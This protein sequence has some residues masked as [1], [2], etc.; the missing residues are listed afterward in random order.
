M[1]SNTTRTSESPILPAVIPLT[2]TLF[3]PQPLVH[4]STTSHTT[5]DA[6]N[7]ASPPPS[8]VPISTTVISITTGTTKPTSDEPSTSVSYS[9]SSPLASSIS[10]LPSSSILSAPAPSS[11]PSSTTRPA[12]TST[13][14][15]LSASN[16]STRITY[17]AILP[18]TFGAFILISCIL[19]VRRYC[20]RRNKISEPSIISKAWNRLSSTSPS[21]SHRTLGPGDSLSQ[22]HLVER[23]RPR[24]REAS[25]ARRS[26][27]LRRARERFIARESAVGRGQV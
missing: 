6:T 14:A 1:P 9:Q 13:P 22:R 21:S 2:L 10:N 17:T 25:E 15:A 26:S 11:I 16:N 7:A 20:R 19:F 8:L 5:L 12:T 24:I 23:G 18:A 27:L 4:P 3:S